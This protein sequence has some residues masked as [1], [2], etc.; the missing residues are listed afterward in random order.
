MSERD[1]LKALY[2]FVNAAEKSRKYA[3]NTAAGMKAAIGLYEQVLS[4]EE[5]ESLE[6]FQTRFDA[7]TQEMFNKNATEKTAGTLDTYRKRVHKVISE[8]FKYG[9]DRSKFVNWE[10]IRR[11]ST[12]KG[13]KRGETENVEIERELNTKTLQGEND[14]HRI[15]LENDRTVII[16]TPKDITRKEVIRIEGYLKYLSEYVALDDTS[17]GVA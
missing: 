12:P 7:I 17:G 3:K 1:N 4:G 10:P 5:K 11:R 6:M 13:K 9:K 2:D 15:S 16:M 14:T 8:Y